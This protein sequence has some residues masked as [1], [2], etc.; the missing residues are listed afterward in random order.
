MY[1]KQNEFCSAGTMI[2]AVGTLYSANSMDLGTP[3]TPILASVALGNKLGTGI[4]PL[5]A[6]FLITTT[7]LAAGG[8]STVVFFVARG[9]GVTAGGVL[10]AGQ[11]NIAVSPAI[12]KASILAGSYGYLPI[13]PDFGQERYLGVGI[14]IATNDGTAGA[15]T[16]WLAPLDAIQQSTP[17]LITKMW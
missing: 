15:Y 9:T 17:P 10:N 3:G 13:P 6:V 8:A 11:R 14:T 7:Y 5:V 12:S 2:Q 1:D 16:A 4:R